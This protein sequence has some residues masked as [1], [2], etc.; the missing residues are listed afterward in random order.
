MSTP[1]HFIFLMLFFGL[2]AMFDTSQV[3]QSW[4]K[5]MKKHRNTNRGL[6]TRILWPKRSVDQR[7]YMGRGHDDGVPVRFTTPG[8]DGWYYY[9]LNVDK[10]MQRAKNLEGYED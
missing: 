8:S 3:S 10:G 9:F 4:L 1:M 2:I 6:G 7:D 5:N